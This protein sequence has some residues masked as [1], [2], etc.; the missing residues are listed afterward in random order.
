MADTL[1]STQDLTGSGQNFF[2]TTL[3]FTYGVVQINALGSAR[4]LDM[5]DPSRIFQFGWFALSQPGPGSFPVSGAEMYSNPVFI[6]WEVM[7]IP[8]Q[9]DFPFTAEFYADAI[10]FAICAGGDATLTLWHV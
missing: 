10:R 3:A 4:K 1:V 6:E 5:A 9:L 8:A 2:G 7:Q